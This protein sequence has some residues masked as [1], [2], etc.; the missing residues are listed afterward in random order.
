DGQHV[1]QQIGY[2]IKGHMRRPLGLQEFQLRRHMRGQE[3]IQGAVARR[4][5][6]ILAG[7]PQPAWAS[8]L[9]ITK[10]GSKAQRV[11]TLDGPWPMATRTVS[12]PLNMLGELLPYQLV[13]QATQERFRLLQP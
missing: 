9:Q 1:M 6:W 10:G 3:R 11:I 12:V 2:R 13:L 4:G 8:K 7:A 5:R